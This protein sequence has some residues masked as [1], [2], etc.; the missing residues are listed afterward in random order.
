MDELPLQWARRC[1]AGALSPLSAINQLR[2]EASGVDVA[3]DAGL[4]ALGSSMKE[5]A[6]RCCWLWRRPGESCVFIPGGPESLERTK[7]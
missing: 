1:L 7:P 2:G 4:V 5:H 6:S 3:G